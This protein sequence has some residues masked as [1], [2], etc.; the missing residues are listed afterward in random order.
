MAVDW[1]STRITGTPSRQGCTCQN[2][3]VSCLRCD[4]YTREFRESAIGL[5][6][7]QGLSIRTAAEDEVRLHS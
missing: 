4:F 6:M 3:R 5:V 2:E 1:T 7:S